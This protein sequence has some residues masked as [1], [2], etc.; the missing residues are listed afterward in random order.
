M[1]RAAGAVGNSGPAP[2]AGRAGAGAR[3]LTETR[4]PV[5]KTEAGNPPVLIL[6][7]FY[8][9]LGIAR[10]MAGRGVRVIGLSA[11][12][13]AFG[14]FTRLCEVRPAPSS[15]EEPEALANYLLSVASDLDGAV[16]FP[17]CDFDVLFLDRFRRQ[18]E[19]YYRLAIPPENCPARILDKAALAGIAQ[20]AGLSVP[21]TLKVSTPEEIDEVPR[22]IAFPCVVKPVRSVHWHGG[23]N[24]LRAGSRKGFL[25]HT[26]EE[27]S[28]GYRQ[29][30]AVHP[31]VLVQEWIPG[32]VEN[33]VIMGA[34]VGEDSEPLAYFTARKI[35]Q[36][37]EDFGTGC[38]VRSEDAPELLGPSR[39]LWQA[40]NYQGMAEVEFKRDPRTGEYRLIEMNAR[41]W[42][43]HELGCVSGV[44][45]TSVAYCHLTGQPV[46]IRR[47]LTR[48]AVWIA[49]DELLSYA[50]RSAIQGRLRLRPLLAGLSPPRMWGAFRWRDPQPL[51]RRMAMEAGPSIVR[52]IKR[53]LWPKEKKSGEAS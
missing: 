12:R 6:N 11:N 13:K 40:L 46:P 21:Q 28:R 49:E 44:N 22:R 50:V 4:R 48:S 33:I 52:K 2:C 10:A 30:S 18:L 24:W 16:I 7:M 39:R 9:G 37:P 20:W 17:T 38:V 35:I 19:P 14:N 29:V 31:E 25:A 3:P 43:Q 8:S 5:A 26:A 34:Y 36:S 41:H 27:L 42:D 15:C 53:T 32:G 1:T 23:D 51:F 47:G 45:L